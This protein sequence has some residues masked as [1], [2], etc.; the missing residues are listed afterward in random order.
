MI[1]G[2]C[3][4]TRVPYHTSYLPR[5]YLTGKIVGRKSMVG[6][7]HQEQ[8]TGS[9]RHPSEYLL[10]ELDFSFCLFSSM[11]GQ[12][13]LSANNS[14]NPTDHKHFDG[15]FKDLPFYLNNSW[16]SVMPVAYGDMTDGR[17]WTG[18]RST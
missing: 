11:I 15:G 18:V 9:I 6:L 12:K 13:P 1:D 8:M 10:H 7:L 5:L 16:E 2:T 17:R 3:N 4:E 14:I